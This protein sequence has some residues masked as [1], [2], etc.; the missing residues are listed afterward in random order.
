MNSVLYFCSAACLVSTRWDLLSFKEVNADFCI[1]VKI[2]ATSVSLG[3]STQG[4]R[5]DLYTFQLSLMNF[6]WDC[7]VWY[8]LTTTTISI[9]T[10]VLKMTALCVPEVY[11]YFK[12]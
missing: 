2:V 5:Y 12:P 9:C 10:N 3:L 6:T 11:H 7:C 1:E 4:S 8:T